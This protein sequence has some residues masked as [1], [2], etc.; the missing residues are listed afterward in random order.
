VLA[1]VV[2]S[3]IL[4]PFT[5]PALVQ[6][7]VGQ[8]TEMPLLAMIRL[9][10]TMIFIPMLLVE[11]AARFAPKILAK[12]SEVQFGIALPLFAVTNLGVFSKY[13]E[14]LNQ[15]TSVLVQALVVSIAVGAMCFFGGILVSWKRPLSDQASTVL[16]FGYMNT[17][18]AM[19]FGSEFFTPLEPTTAGV[20]H[21]PLLGLIVALRYYQGLRAKFPVA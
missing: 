19:I 20:Y 21:V 9:L 12:I 17:I 15:Q 8:S 11:I 18:L 16:S 5:L 4:V 2:G 3:S 1:M 10:S 6:V 13:S 14:F 7:L